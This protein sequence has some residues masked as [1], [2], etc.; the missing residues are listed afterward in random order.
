MSVSSTIPVTPEEFLAIPDS[1]RFEL[2]GGELVERNMGW[3]S[4]RIAL[5]LNWLLQTH[6]AANDLG[7]VLGNDCGYRIFADDPNKVRFPDGSF[8]AKSRLNFDRSSTGHLRLPPDLA[9]EVVSPND[10]A[11]DIEAKVNDF[12]N[13][14]VRLVWVLY[15]KTKHVW[16]YRPDQS[17]HRLEANDT[18]MGEDVLPGFSCQVATL[19]AL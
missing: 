5:I 3:E 4:S 14:G 11:W 18:L 9:F 15:P 1:V 19:F 7:W 16:V 8:I 12:L 13:A 17:Q 2:V 10:L 6:A